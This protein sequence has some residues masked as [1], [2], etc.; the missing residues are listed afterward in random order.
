MLECPS[1]RREQGLDLRQGQQ[2]GAALS[3]LWQLAN[4]VCDRTARDVVL[5]QERRIAHE[6][7]CPE[8]PVPGRK[9][10]LA[11]E[12]VQVQPGE[13]KLQLAV[14]QAEKTDAPVPQ[15]HLLPGSGRLKDDSEEMLQE[16][17]ETSQHRRQRQ[18]RLQRRFLEDD[19]VLFELL[20]P[21]SHVPS[22]KSLL[23]VL[24][25]EGL[26]LLQLLTCSR[27]AAGPQRAQQGHHLALRRH[28]RLKGKVCEACKAKS[29]R[30]ELSVRQHRCE[31]ASIPSD[32][33]VIASGTQPLQRLKS[34]LPQ[35][36]VLGLH[37]Q[38]LEHLRPRR[39][40]P[41]TALFC[42]LVALSCSSLGCLLK[43][44]P[45]K[46]RH[47][48]WVCAKRKEL[49][50]VVGNILC[51]DRAEK[52]ELFVAFIKGT[53]RACVLQS[54]TPQ[55]AVPQQSLHHAVLRFAQVFTAELQ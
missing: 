30:P 35:P 15:R 20:S 4:D 17:K 49:C 46:A 7:V 1:G 41:R 38:C 9:L 47:C 34:L 21:V 19:L 33:A 11:S 22:G 12:Q 48:L 23:A 24:I 51:E 29:V 40:K 26:E 42:C 14:N 13:W 39:E 45:R 52:A 27:L 43:D 2:C 28:P 3:R 6:G 55:K 5:A 54:H 44:L 37:E 16:A 10:L 36:R 18:V 53:E 32:V 50:L 25:G 31:D 8:A